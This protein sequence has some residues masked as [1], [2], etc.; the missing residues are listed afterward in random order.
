M[1]LM[2]GITAFLTLGTVIDAQITQ[3]N[4]VDCAEG[5]DVNL[6]CNHSTI[7]REDEYIY[8]YRQI[9]HQGPEYVIYGL[10][11]NVTNGMASLTITTDRKSSILILPQVT[12]RDTAVYYCIV[13]EAHWDRWGCTCARSP[14]W[15]KGSS[16]RHPK[17]TLP[18]NEQKPKRRRRKVK[19]EKRKRSKDK[20]M[21]KS[22]RNESN[23]ED[24]E[25]RLTLLKRLR[26]LGE[27]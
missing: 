15:G 11:S 9:P 8:W 5:E 3:P 13:R 18:Q 4:S 24:E 19:E 7:V 27:N 26:S 21:R 25:E 20:I 16:S 12:L 6:P 23:K 14:W 17:M 2:T 10:K 1:R 22:R